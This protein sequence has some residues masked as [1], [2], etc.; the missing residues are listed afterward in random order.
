MEGMTYSFP[1]IATNQ[2]D[3]AGNRFRL[4]YDVVFNNVP[5]NVNP[6][7]SYFIS[8]GLAVYDSGSDE[9]RDQSDYFGP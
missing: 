1:S 2:T 3:G 9:V 5:E 8:A 7:G 6:A 4:D